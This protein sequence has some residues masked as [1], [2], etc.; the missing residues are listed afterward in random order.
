M[1]T[2][3]QSKFLGKVNADVDKQM[4]GV[5]YGYLQLPTGVNMY[6]PEVGTTVHMDIMPYV[7]SN[8]RHP[9]RN[10]EKE[11]ATAGSLWYKLPFKTH[12]DVGV[13]KE[14]LVCPTSFGLPCPICEHRQ[15]RQDAGA[16]KAELQTMNASRRNLY[17][18]NP[19]DDP[20]ATPDKFY[21][22]DMSQ[23]LFQ[24]EL[25]RDLK[26]SPQ[27]EG[28][29]DLEFG[30]MLKCRWDGGSM[31]G[32]KPFP[33][34]GRIDFIQR[35]EGYDDAVLDQ[36]PDLDKLLIVLSYA[37]IQAK[38]FELEE[39]EEMQDEAPVASSPAP[40]RRAPA[41]AT[42]PAAP[43][44]R[45]AAPAPAPAAPAA[46]TRRA[47]APTPA[48][49]APTRRAPAPAPAAAPTRRAPEPVVAPEPIEEEGFEPVEELC[50]ACEGTGKTSRGNVCPICKGTGLKPQPEEPLVE[51]PAA[52]VRRAAA[53]APA[54]A[55]AP[56]RRAPAP[57]PA[58]EPV[59]EGGQTCP[60]GFVWGRD[61]EEDDKCDACDLWSECLDAKQA[62]LQ[63]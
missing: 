3:K 53:P 5:K 42:A 40:T 50:I 38:F 36:I 56:T 24:D 20:K 6:S 57:T 51:R 9:D 23:Y 30:F 48:P 54:P 47:P 45:A 44:R 25:N 43:V 63:A 17:A 14:T 2:Q 1:T 35:S 13:E 32:S 41:P 4:S 22:F 60:N 34:C 31:P 21:V 12:R 18:V 59:A 58:P 10:M 39:G 7:V 16:D 29:P 8:P 37:E 61:C 11:I 15:K 49:A 52:P 62:F 33:E 46:P 55:A 27:Y 19:I 26:A 28:F